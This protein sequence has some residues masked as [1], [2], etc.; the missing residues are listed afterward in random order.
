MRMADLASSFL[1]EEEKGHQWSNKLANILNQSLHCYPRD[2]NIKATSAKVKLP[3]SVEN[4][5]VPVTQNG[6]MKALTTGSIFSML[7]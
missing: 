2:D 1:G 6:I 7:D 5:K 3:N 4:L